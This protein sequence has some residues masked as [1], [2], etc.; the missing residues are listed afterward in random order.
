MPEEVL[1]YSISPTLGHPITDISI[2]LVWRSMGL[3]V[4]YV[5]LDGV[6]AQFPENLDDVDIKIAAACRKWCDE[7]GEHHSDFEGIF[8]TFKPMEGADDAISRLMQKFEVYILSTAP[9]KNVSSWTEKRIWVEKNLPSLPKKKLIISNNKSLVR[10]AY[11]IDDRP[12]HGAAEFG[13]IEGQEWIHFGSEDFPDW[14][15]V[16]NHL[17]C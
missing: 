5:D 12:K 8:S 7:T 13:D 11:L 16:L 14:N 3:P 4:L 1:V 15:S 2:L 9:W 10:G 17:N 6:L